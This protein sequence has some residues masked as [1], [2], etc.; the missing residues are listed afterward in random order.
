[1]INAKYRTQF[2]IVCA[3]TLGLS[4]FGLYQTSA[5]AAGTAKL[6]H[7]H[8]VALVKPDKNAPLPVSPAPEKGNSISP[9]LIPGGGGCS[10]D[11]LTGG[12]PEDYGCDQDAYTVAS[13]NIYNGH[14]FNIGVVELRW[15]PACQTNWSR[16]TSYIGSGSGVELIAKV[17]RGDGVSECDPAGPTSNNIYG[18]VSVTNTVS[19]W[20]AMVYAPSQCASALGYVHQLLGYGN[21]GEGSNQTPCY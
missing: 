6:K 13:R 10:G 4:F 8:A 12:K 7:P 21:N 2:S 15:S 14:G 11:C 5:H 19:T 18:C 9:K 17:T 20:S 3:L 1:V 16:T